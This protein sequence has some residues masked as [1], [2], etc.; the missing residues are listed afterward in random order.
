MKRKAFVTGSTGF[1]GLNLVALLC[2]ND[3]EVHALHRA[4]SDLRFLSRFRVKLHTG[5]ITNPDSLLTAMPDQPDAVFHLAG[6]TSLWSRANRKQRHVNVDGTYHVI[7]ASKA[8]GA[9]VLVHTSSASTWGDM[10][11]RT[12]TESLPQRGGQSWVGYER[13]K[14]EAEQLVNSC[15]P[16]E[17][18]TVILN[19]TTVT[20]PYDLNNWGRLFFALRNGELPGIPDGIISVSH[21]REVVRAHLAAVDRG[22]HGERYLLS[23][24]D[25]HFSQFVKEI[26]KISGVK[27]LP[28]NLPTSLLKAVAYVSLFRSSFS[29][30]EPDITP[31]L[32]RL[33]TR[34]GLTY[35]SNKAIQELAY[36]IVPMEVSVRDTYNWL[37]DEAFL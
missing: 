7:Q 12:I 15:L 25:C 24:E 22:R 26:A 10:S 4:T 19:P 1:I 34:T 13:T 18:R 31:E 33:M 20:G 8:K 14:W 2:E 5:C 3:W 37:V 35:S 27:T 17:L 16:N 28:R 30:R 23:G 32:V 36:R 9:G 29:G 11:G 6:N 21:V